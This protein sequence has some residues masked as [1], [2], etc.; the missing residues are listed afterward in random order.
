MTTDTSN[1]PELAAEFH[2]TDGDVGVYPVAPG[3]PDAGLLGLWGQF[4]PVADG[5]PS[6]I[7]IRPNTAEGQ[8]ISNRL[9]AAEKALRAC[10][11]LV[12]AYARG[13]ENGSSIDWGDVDLAWEVASQAMAIAQGKPALGD[14]ETF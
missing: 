9:C 1:T 13:E 3:S 7:V 5:A 2:Y 10:E 6:H 12:A 11:L 14:A 4:P 8:D